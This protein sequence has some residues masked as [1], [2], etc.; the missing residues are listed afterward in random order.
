MTNAFPRPI[1]AFDNNFELFAIDRVVVGLALCKS[2]VSYP[3]IYHLSCN[4]LYRK[5][6]SRLQKIYNDGLPTARHTTSTS[7]TVYNGCLEN[8]DR[9][10]EQNVAFSKKGAWVKESAFNKAFYPAEESISYKGGLVDGAI[11]LTST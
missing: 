6:E 11:V 4:V 3:Y 5:G 10:A 7:Y 1:P 2:S 9:K 8:I